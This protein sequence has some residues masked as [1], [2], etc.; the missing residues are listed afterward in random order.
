MIGGFSAFIPN[1][2][3]CERVRYCFYRRNSG[4]DLSSPGYLSNVVDH[5]YTWL[6]VV[7]MKG[8][9]DHVKIPKTYTL[10]THR[11]LCVGPCMLLLQC[12]KL[13]LLLLLLLLPLP[14]AV[15]GT[16]LHDL[17]IVY[18]KNGGAA[19][20]ASPISA[21]H[22]RRTWVGCNQSQPSWIKVLARN[23]RRQHT[24]SERLTRGLF[25]FV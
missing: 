22:R 1:F 3:D 20:G 25:C 4:P 13:L 2:G 10:S 15:D 23:A 5:M 19:A 12:Q 17:N 7:M 16:S 6:D 18:F 21:N 14:E 8:A 24:T 9:Y 11:D